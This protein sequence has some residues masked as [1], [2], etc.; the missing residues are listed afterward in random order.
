MNRLIEKAAEKALPVLLTAGLAVG[1]VA[2]A[3][4]GYE[5]VPTEPSRVIN[6]EFIPEHN[7]T[8]DGPCLLY[9]NGVCLLDGDTIALIDDE[10]N[11]QIE[12]CQ[13]GPRRSKTNTVCGTD[14]FEVSQRE[15]ESLEVGDIVVIKQDH[16]EALPQ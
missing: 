12:Q 11:M 4:A 6:L 13:E 3:E 7:V 16:V 15:Y 2:C 10:W 14:N 1:A 5:V 8:I 9:S